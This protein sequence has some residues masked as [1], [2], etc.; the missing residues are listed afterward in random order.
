MREFVGDWACIDG[1]S[2]HLIDG[3]LAKVTNQPV[4][5]VLVTKIATDANDKLTVYDLD[6]GE[7]TYSQVILTPALGCMQAMDLD[8]CDFLYNQKLAIRSL[9]YDSSTKVALKF[10]CRWWE[11][12]TFMEGKTIQG[13]VSD[14]DIP[15]RVCAYPS[16]GFDCPPGSALPGVLLASYTWAQDARRI[17]ALDHRPLSKAEDILKELVLDNLCKLHGFL[18]SK[19]PPLEGFYV[20][21]W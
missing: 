3:M 2:D 11:D 5:D 19:L 21:D 1:G 20:F 9:Q 13:G 16:Y 4:T 12:S 15:I 10:S 17:G 18:R 8:G 14:T 7:R 6:G